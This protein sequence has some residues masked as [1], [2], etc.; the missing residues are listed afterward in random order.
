MVKR[1]SFS[2]SREAVSELLDNA[3]GSRECGLADG[4]DM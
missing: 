2:T 3:R 1:K 4:L